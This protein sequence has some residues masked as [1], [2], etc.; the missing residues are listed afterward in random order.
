MHRTRTVLLQSTLLLLGLTGLALQV[1]VIPPL[2]TT[3]AAP[4]PEAQPLVPVTIGWAVLVIACG[5]AGLAL[6]WRLVDLMRDGRIFTAAS[7]GPVRL[8]VACPAAV[9]VLTL[10]A[11]VAFDSAAV[12]P[13]AIMLVL[14]GIIVASFAATLALLTSSR[15]LRQA[16]AMRA[17]LAEVV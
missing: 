3:A 13:P 2:V 12:T 8:L 17:D 16:A 1:L 5:Q 11:Y 10:A 6:V 15:L 14:L 4:Y 7:A 9:G